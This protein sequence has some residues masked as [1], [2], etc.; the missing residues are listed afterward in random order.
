MFL[1]LTCVTAAHGQRLVKGTVKSSA[2]EP[3]VGASVLLKGTTQGTVAD[4]N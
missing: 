4:I 3:L 2:G 1:L